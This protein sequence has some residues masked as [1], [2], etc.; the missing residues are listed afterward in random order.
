MSSKEIKTGGKRTSQGQHS[1]SHGNRHRSKIW[2]AFSQSKHQTESSRQT[3]VKG[4]LPWRARTPRPRDQFR[5]WEHAARRCPGQLVPPSQCWRSAEEYFDISALPELLMPWSP[6]PSAGAPTSSS[7]RPSERSLLP[8]SKSSLLRPLGWAGL[9]S[10]TKWSQN[11]WLRFCWIGEALQCVQREREA[12]R[13]RR[14][15]G[16]GRRSLN[17]K[18][19]LSL[20]FESLEASLG[21]LHTKDSSPTTLAM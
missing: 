20:G 15:T 8:F 7:M 11:Y 18:P 4:S 14:R 12:A 5:S 2:K 13:R 1:R 3:K 21:P 9:D 17:P 10:T 6:S 19:S 16:R